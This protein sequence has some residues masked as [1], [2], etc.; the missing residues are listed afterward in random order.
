MTDAERATTLDDYVRRVV[1]A[2]PPLTADQ[3]A[4][5][6]VLLSDPPAPAEGRK[7]A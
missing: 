1:D 4:R 5:V 3:A 6:R 7:A 2:A